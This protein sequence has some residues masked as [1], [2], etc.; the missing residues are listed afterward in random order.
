MFSEI[1]EIRIKKSA[2][3]SR[4]AL[5]LAS[6]TATIAFG[7]GLSMQALEWLKNY[8]IMEV[9]G[10]TWRPIFDVGRQTTRKRSA[11]QANIPQNR[12]ELARKIRTKFLEHAPK[13]IEKLRAAVEKKDPVGIKREAH[14]LKSSGANVGAS[15]FSELCQLMEIYALNN[16]LS[17]S[18]L[19]LSDIDKEFAKVQAELNDLQSQDAAEATITAPPVS[20]PKYEIKSAPRF[21][22]GTNAQPTFEKAA[23]IEIVASA[24]P[25]PLFDAR[26]L[27]VEDSPINQEWALEFLSDLVSYVAVAEDGQQAVDAHLDGKF[28]MIFMDCQMPEMDGFQATR[29]IRKRERNLE[30]PPVPI[31]ALT[32]NALRGDRDKCLAAGMDDYISKPFAPESLR[33]TVEK[34]LGPKRIAH[35]TD[36]GGSRPAPAQAAVGG[37]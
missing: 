28:D 3:R 35:R 36:A 7:A 4:N 24:K 6:N 37:P 17:K 9:S 19:L 22:S 29:L 1:Q 12:P 30:L 13:A 27:L 10:L 14:W 32:A 34:W 11:G 16:D 18:G 25:A 2:R 8:L 15:H 5:V 33:A 26:V 21:G 31:I 20:L 23:A